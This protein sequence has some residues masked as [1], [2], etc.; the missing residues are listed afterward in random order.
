MSSTTRNALLKLALPL[1][2]D[3]GFT[4]SALSLAVMYSPSGKHTAPLSD[5][6]V[7]A[8]FGEGDEARRTLINAWLD[9]ARVSL[10][11]FY[12]QDSDTATTARN[13]SLGNVLKT[14]LSKNEGVLEHL[15]EVRARL[16]S[17][18]RL[19]LLMRGSDP[20]RH[21]LSSLHRQR[22]PR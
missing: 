3:H 14:R 5:T 16:N 1:I 9:D 7:D 21:L 19:P 15:P 11:K 17:D 8:L 6:A 20:L 22:C 12:S 18:M 2:K 13:P 4:R 10:R